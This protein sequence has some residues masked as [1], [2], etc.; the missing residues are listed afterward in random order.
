MRYPIDES[1]PFLSESPA[2]APYVA[3]SP[4]IT[5]SPYIKLPYTIPSISGVNTPIS[6][7]EAESPVPEVEEEAPILEVEEGEEEAPIPGEAGEAGEAPIPEV[8]AET[9]DTSTQ[10]DDSNEVPLERYRRIAIYSDVTNTSILLTSY[11]DEDGNGRIV[12]NDVDLPYSEFRDHIRCLTSSDKM[13]EDE[14]ANEIMYMCVN[15]SCITGLAIS[16]I[17]IGIAL[18]M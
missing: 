11:I 8:E 13:R 18:C 4:Y 10:V 9:S 14:R 3:E 15:V 2:I 1:S 6:E 12:L 5:E 16:L 7:V 17:T